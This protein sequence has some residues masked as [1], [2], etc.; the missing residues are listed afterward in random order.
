M[1]TRIV[2]QNATLVNEGD[3]FQGSVLIEDGRIDSVKR[4]G[5]IVSPRALEVDGSDMWLMPGVIDDHVHMRD[6]GLTH[7]GN[8]DSETAAAAAGG[9]T[10]VMDMPNVVPQTTTLEL[11]E[12]RRRLGAL[13]CHVNYAFYMGATSDNIEE[14]KGIDPA[15]VPGVKVFMGSSTGNMLVDDDQ[16]LRRIFSASPTMVMV[17]CEDAARIDARMTEAVARYGDDPDVRLHPQIRDAEACYHSTLRAVSLARETG[18]RLHVAHLST[19][20]EL[21][22]FRAGDPLVTA[23]AC[24]AHLLFTDADYA[25]LGTRIKCNPAVKGVSDRQ[26]LREALVDGR[27]ALVGTDHAPHL[28]TEKEGGCRRAA[29]GM[30]MVQYSL[31]AMLTLSDEGVL[32]RWRVVELMAHAPARLFGISDRGFIREGYKADLVLLSRKPRVVSRDSILSLCGWSPL[33]GSTLGWTVERT[34][35]N[36]ELVWDGSEIN[37]R[38]LGEALRFNRQP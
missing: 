13:N 32:P 2:I 4:D 6:P 22:L 11:F 24:V 16:A 5:L 29:S 17:H 21:S 36:G 37:R 27:I 23:E 28:L 35:V 38:V 30:P 20:L 3:E 19:E 15:L 26:A 34:W 7:K 8:M 10:S 1:N 9:V 18:A 33:E 25:R 12:E 14:I 31:P